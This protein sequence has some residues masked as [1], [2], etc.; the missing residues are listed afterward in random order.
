MKIKLIGPKDPALTA[1]LDSIAAH[2][3]WE[4]ELKLIPWAAYRDTLM[5]TLSAEVA[6]HQ[7]VFVPGHVWI[8]EL[9]ARGLIVPL[10]PLIADL[11]AAI[12][13]DYGWE[14]VISSIQRESR[15]LDQLY[16]IPFF[17]DSHILF[18]REDLVQLEEAG[19]LPEISPLDLL[20]LAEKAHQP[21]AVYGIALKAHPSEILFD[22]LPYL[23]AAGG[24]LADSNF[25]P[26]FFSE[27]GIRALALYCQLKACAPPQTHTFGNEEIAAVLKG[28]KAALVATWGGQASPIFLDENNPYR[29]LYRSAVYPHPCGGTWGI[30]LPANQSRESQMKTMDMVLALN[31]PGVDR[32][33]LLA[34]GSPIRHSSYTPGA[35][36]RYFWLRAQLK[37]YQ[38]ISLL[39][40]D[41]RIG[42]FLEPLTEG[43]VR[44][45]Q[46]EQ[47]PR[48][49][50]Q[51]AAS[52]ILQALE[53]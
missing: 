41:P 19:E 53:G 39:P 30:A 43:L 4:A 17:N 16:M 40:F 3:E 36:D 20:V 14:D 45:F 51:E 34:A 49:A 2:P 22:W 13:Q 37:V 47:A 23:L 26:A 38:R 52:R 24:Q 32:D 15:Y 28:G 33:V 5:E 46:G 8:P 42:L 11:P 9:A 44:A 48:D 7:A 50:L 31:R 21:P 29:D 1:A 25:K 27:A 35:L 12:W 6:P 18:Y 10:N